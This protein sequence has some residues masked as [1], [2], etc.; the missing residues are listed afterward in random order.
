MTSWSG[1]VGEIESG[2]IAKQGT[3][4]LVCG[5]G[6][7]GARVHDWSKGVKLRQLEEEGYA[8]PV[9]DLMG[10]ALSDDGRLAAVQS[11][12]KE[13]TLWDLETRRLLRRLQ[14][15]HDSDLRL[16]DGEDSVSRGKRPSRGAR[17]VRPSNR[18]PTTWRQAIRSGPSTPCGR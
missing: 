18:S 3:K 5:L 12:W 11:A 2:A 10:V 15:H 17:I 6:D 7:W 16:G 14:G 4:L 1:G 8:W 13:V 9:H